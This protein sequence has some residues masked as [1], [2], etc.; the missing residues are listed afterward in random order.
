MDQ[1]VGGSDGYDPGAMMW[2][3][4]I[5]SLAGLGRDQH[6][7]ALASP[8]PREA[9]ARPRRP[10]RSP[11]ARR[12]SLALRVVAD[13]ADAEDVVQEVFDQAWRRASAATARGTVIA[14][15]AE[16]GTHAGDRSSA[17]PAC[18]ARSRG[19][20]TNTRGASCRDPWIPSTLS[21]PPATR[22]ASSRRCSGSADPARRHRPRVF[23]GTDPDG[24][25]RAA[26]RAAGH[27]EDAHSGR[28]AQAARRLVGVRIGGA[29]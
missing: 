3:S 14:L 1:D 6:E 4:A 5:S 16:H 9:T 10:G 18:P 2:L 26:R 22:C 23:R 20:G 21:T 15:A 29:I 19:P 11:R 27:R 7:D 12:L 24:D 28:A 8:T 25:R 13:E 17:R